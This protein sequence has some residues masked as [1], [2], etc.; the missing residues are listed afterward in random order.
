MCMVPVSAD[1]DVLSGNH[2]EIIV[3][4]QLQGGLELL[5]ADPHFTLLSQLFKHGVKLQL[6]S[7]LPCGL[8]SQQKQNSVTTACC[9]VKGSLLCWLKES[10][11]V[12]S[13]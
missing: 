5:V 1:S 8:Q 7:C 10:L 12:A 6:G 9:K 13:S 4:Q 2:Q 3:L 11:P